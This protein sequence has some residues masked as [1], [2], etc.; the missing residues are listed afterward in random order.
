MNQPFTEGWFPRK[1]YIKA[2]HWPQR[3]LHI[4]SMTS[5]ARDEHGAYRAPGTQ[6]EI[7]PKYNILT[8]TWGRFRTEDAAGNLALPVQNT[9]WKIPPIKKEHFT[10]DQFKSVVAF[11]A[12]DGI[13]WAWIDI[14]CIHQEDEAENAEEVGRQASIFKNAH[15]VFVWLSELSFSVLAPAIANIQDHG[16]QLRK[17]VDNDPTALPIQDIISSLLK[18]CNIIFNEPWFSSLWTLQE[19]VLRNDALVLAKEAEPIEWFPNQYMYM[20][21]F[22]NHCQNMFRDLE[23]LAD[24]IK[25]SKRH[26]QPISEQ[27]LRMGAQ[28]HDIKQRI[29]EA[30]FYY[31]FSDNPNVQY[32]TA[33]YRKTSRTVDRVY[34]IMQV[35][36]IRVGKSL[37]PAR[38]PQLPELLDEFAK[39][40]VDTCPIMSQMFVH[41][42]APADGASWRITEASRVPDFLCMYR[43]P[44]PLSELVI[45]SG[46]MIARGPLCSF[47]HIDEIDQQTDISLK[48]YLD[49]YVIEDLGFSQS[50]L[51]REHIHGRQ[52]LKQY[53]YGALQVFWLGSVQRNL[54]SVFVREQIG[55][56]LNPLKPV[57]GKEQLQSPIYQRLGICTWNFSPSKSLGYEFSPNMPWRQVDIQIH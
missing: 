22:I 45:E 10:V 14:A 3:L 17:H 26:N 27:Q 43:D 47:V 9:P 48:I 2:D 51:S 12:S 8:Y 53:G 4:P 5:V 16:I 23:Y 33:K 13:K 41:T 35:Y 57:E 40:I 15:R 38:N 56:I 54:E 21:M 20:T 34:A 31:T 19:V 11:L 49:E 28:I 30:G 24:S 18:E 32:G 37:D 7:R 6:D 44:K 29:L 50:T 46:V 39:A 42:R 36:N 25:E 52:L 55:I 1:W